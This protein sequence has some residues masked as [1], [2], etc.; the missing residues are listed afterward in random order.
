[1]EFIKKTIKL[2]NS[3][4][5]LLPKKLL[6][7]EVKITV[8]KRPVNI[9]KEIMKAVSQ[10]LPD[11]LGIYVIDQ[12]P[13]E[14]IVVS[15]NIR[16]ILEKENMKIIFVPWPIIKKDI[17]TNLNLRKKLL[18]AKIILNKALISKLKSEI[19]HYRL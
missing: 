7:S 19:E 13:I 9:R 4:G 15:S 1:M 10:Y 6:G 18:N 14:A 8:V 12:K 16:K 3:S 17:R 5:V 11:I 2:G